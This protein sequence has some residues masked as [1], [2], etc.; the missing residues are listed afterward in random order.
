MPLLSSRASEARA[1]GLSWRIMRQ[2]AAASAVLLALGVVAVALHAG[3]T[4]SANTLLAKS[5]PGYVSDKEAQQDMLSY[6]DMAKP[7]LKAELEQVL[8]APAQAAKTKGKTGGGDKQLAKIDKELAQEK[9]KV[10]QL[11]AKKDALEHEF[12][13]TGKD[14]K[15]KST[16]QSLRW[17]VYPPGGGATTYSNV[18]TAKEGDAKSKECVPP[19][20]EVDGKCQNYLK[21]SVVDKQKARVALRKDAY[22][23]YKWG[24]QW[25]KHG[26][27]HHFS[28]VPQR[29]PHED[30]ADLGDNYVGLDCGTPDCR[31][32][33]LADKFKSNDGKYP[34]ARIPKLF[35]PF[36][37]DSFDLRYAARPQKLPDAIKKLDRGYIDSA[38][39]GFFKSQK[40]GYQRYMEQ[41]HPYDNVVRHPSRTDRFR[42]LASALYRRKNYPKGGGASVATEGWKSPTRSSAIGGKAPSLVAARGHGPLPVVQGPKTDAERALLE[43]AGGGAGLFGDDEMPAG[44]ILM[45]KAQDAYMRKAEGEPVTDLGLNN[46]DGF[47]GVAD[48]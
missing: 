20:V 8:K 43:G 28:L 35:R 17:R 19:K 27:K 14:G 5:S 29:Y 46:W 40:L 11:K 7:S 31:Q 33:N 6:F 4:G 39:G 26:Y 25:R 45:D 48:P 22:Y 37:G 34:H 47:N 3:S 38:I 23:R 1:G 32:S 44:K 36:T 18:L 2:P 16:A 42:P 30:G 24:T 13:T 10:Q 41:Y 9:S 15:L 21:M 12:D